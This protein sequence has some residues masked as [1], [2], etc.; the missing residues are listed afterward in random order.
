MNTLPNEILYDILQYLDI[1]SYFR[2]QIA[3]K[4]FHIFSTER[5]IEF[6]ENK[7]ISVRVC[8]CGRCWNFDLP[9]IN[10]IHQSQQYKPMAIGCCSLGAPHDKF[11]KTPHKFKITR[12]CLQNK[13][14]CN[15][16]CPRLVGYIPLQ[17]MDI[18]RDTHNIYYKMTSQREL[19]KD[20][21]AHPLNSNDSNTKLFNKYLT[22]MKEARDILDEAIIELCNKVLI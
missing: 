7:S 11:C 17:H 5:R 19:F 15:G 3:S 14:S 16:N 4:L 13:G 1:K 6:I 10:C 2:T 21:D 12:M 22:K 18:P 8:C 20:I 9:H